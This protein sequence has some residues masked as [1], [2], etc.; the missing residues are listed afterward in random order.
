MA[1]LE[2]QT[3]PYSTISSDCQSP[4][5]THSSKSKTNVIINNHTN[6]IFP[7]ILLTYF[8]RIKNQKIIIKK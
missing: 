5:Q 6:I 3:S 4:V 7:K 8:R 1:L 2:E